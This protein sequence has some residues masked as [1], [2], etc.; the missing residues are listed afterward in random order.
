MYFQK[1]KE[2]D[3]STPP[4][5][6]GLPPWPWPQTGSR[7]DCSFLKHIMFFPSPGLWT[8]CSR[9]FSFSSPSPHAYSKFSQDIAQI[10]SRHLANPTAHVPRC[11]AP[12]R[13]DSFPFPMCARER[14]RVSQTDCPARPISSTKPPPQTHTPRLTEPSRLLWLSDSAQE[15]DSLRL[16]PS[17]VTN[18]MTDLRTSLILRIILGIKCE[19]IYKVHGTGLSI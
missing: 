18:G 10:L 12:S 2:E 1:W 3:K 7:A 19:D 4:G 16:R 6:P 15:P 11:P 9:G 17:F 13:L 5:L 8:D 14:T